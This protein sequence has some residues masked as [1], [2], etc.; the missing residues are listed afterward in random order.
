M[1][2]GTIFG[3]F[4]KKSKIKIFRHF[5]GSGGRPC[6]ATI[7][8]GKKSQ[9]MSIYKEK[10]LSSDGRQIT[11]PDSI[12]FIIQA[13]HPGIDIFHETGEIRAIPGRL[14]ARAKIIVPGYFFFTARTYRGYSGST[15]WISVSCGALFYQSRISRRARAF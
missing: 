14:G 7:S 13:I 8:A 9:K 1:T 11:F 10:L 6:G 3:S 15:S 2:L 4:K 12:D 5:Q